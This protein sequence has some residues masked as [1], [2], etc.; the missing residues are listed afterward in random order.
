MQSFWI[1]GEKNNLKVIY[2]YINLHTL[3]HIFSQMEGTE[4]SQ[5]LHKDNGKVIQ[6]S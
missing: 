5:R 3:E 2:I 6:L 4:I 1:H